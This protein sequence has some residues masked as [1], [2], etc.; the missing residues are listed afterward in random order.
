MAAAAGMSTADA[1]NKWHSAPGI[2]GKR[3]RLASTLMGM[4][5]SKKK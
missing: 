4:N 1:A 2:K 3:A 5:H